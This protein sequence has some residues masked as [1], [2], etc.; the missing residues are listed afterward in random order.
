M[1]LLDLVVV[2]SGRVQM[3]ALSTAVKHVVDTLEGAAGP[4]RDSMSHLTRSLALIEIALALIAI[5][6][7]ERPMLLLRKALN[8]ATWLWLIES[9]HDIA[10]GFMKMLVHAAGDSLGGETKWLLEPGEIIKLSTKATGGMLSKLEGMN[11][12]NGGTVLLL[13]L[14]L[15]A[16]V[17]AYVAL[18]ISVAL[19]NIEFYLYLALSGLLLPFAVLGHTRFLADKAINAVIACAIKLAV[20]SFIVAAIEPVLSKIEF[21]PGVWN[22]LTW[23]SIWAMLVVVGLCTG[24]ALWA[25]RVAAGFLHASPSLSGTA[26]VAQAASVGASLLNTAATAASAAWG[27]TAGAST[28]RKPPSNDSDSG[29]SSGSAPT[30]DAPPPAPPAPIYVF[31][32]SQRELRPPAKPALPSPSG[33]RPLMLGGGS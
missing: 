11:W 31:L 20:M 9:F 17:L 2:Q 30:P 14:A 28:A 21:E 5:L 24:L 16:I 27:A 22:T 6:M 12:F 3:G 10:K 4:L 26:V 18:A 15:L 25:P 23:H 7:G 13:G 8:V 1:V 29:S 19:A 32:A 33:K